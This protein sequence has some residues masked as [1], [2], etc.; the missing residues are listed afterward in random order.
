MGLEVVGR[1]REQQQR[2]EFG[3]GLCGFAE[4]SVLEGEQLEHATYHL[5]VD[6][7]RLGGVHAAGTLK[8][9]PHGLISIRQCSRTALL[10]VTLLVSGYRSGTQTQVGHELVDGFV[11]QLEQIVR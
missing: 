2:Q 7:Q 3:S 8:H 4:R 11:E 1:S 6:Q 5:V 10:R 9:H